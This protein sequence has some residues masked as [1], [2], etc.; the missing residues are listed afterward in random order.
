MK[1]ILGLDIGTNSVGWALVHEPD[2]ND[3]EATYA[4]AGRCAKP[5]AKLTAGMD[6]PWV[7][8]IR[9]GKRVHFIPEELSQE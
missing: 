1:K 5:S 9:D 4:I 8:E 7:L 3:K 6:F 2:E